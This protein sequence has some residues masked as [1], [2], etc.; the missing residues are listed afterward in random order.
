[1]RCAPERRIFTVS[2]KKDASLVRFSKHDRISMMET[3]LGS[4][5]FKSNQNCDSSIFPYYPHGP[6]LGKNNIFVF[7]FFSK[8]YLHVET[9]K[10][11]IC[12]RNAP[13]VRD[14]ILIPF[15]FNSWPAGQR[16]I[17]STLS[18][19]FGQLLAITS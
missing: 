10:P 2:P 14:D 18:T 1:M 13:G 11:E 17:I 5:R 3:L 15:L 4:P 16:N 8:L 19:P 7:I 6:I 12:T 9:I